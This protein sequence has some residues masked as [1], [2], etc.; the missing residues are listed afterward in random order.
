MAVR[1]V[2]LKD[3]MSEKVAAPE[4]PGQISGSSTSR[5]ARRRFAPLI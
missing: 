5:K 4:M 1:T 3:R 2:S